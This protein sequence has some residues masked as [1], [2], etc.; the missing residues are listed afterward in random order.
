[1]GLPRTCPVCFLLPGGRALV[2]PS[3][4]HTKVVLIQ[5]DASSLGRVIGVRAP[6][7]FKL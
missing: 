2:P 1:M 4:A 6:T 3:A 7:I 5:L